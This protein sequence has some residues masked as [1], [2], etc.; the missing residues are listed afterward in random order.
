M[1]RIECP[2]GHVYDTNQYSACPYC[3]NPINVITF[4]GANGNNQSKTTAPGINGNAQF[5]SPSSTRGGEYSQTDL[6]EPNKTVAPGSHVKRIEE[7]NKT[8][9]VFK[10]EHDIDPV[11]GW[12]VCIDGPEKGKDYHL[13][14][15]IN[16]IGRSE[17]MDVCI[18]NDN[19]IS[20]ENHARLAYDPKH[21]NYKL[22]PADSK[23]NIY[24]NDEPVYTP[25]KI[26]AY[27]A[28]ELGMCKMVFIPL[29]NERFN[30]D[31]G[32]T[33]TEC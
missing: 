7:E 12:L 16:T 10:K 4:G 29:C 17:K 15:R 25:T 24:L 20:K 21:N 26:E 18:R 6:G 2:N 23:N 27:D 11:V 8:I 5:G 31:N 33:Q 19:T 13:W 3:N 22:I 1:P 9:G 32:L 30:W 28:I 14:A